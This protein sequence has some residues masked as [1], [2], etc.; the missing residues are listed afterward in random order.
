[1][2]WDRL[3]TCQFGRPL[4][5]GFLFS[6]YGIDELG[7]VPDANVGQV[8]LVRQIIEGFGLEIASPANAREILLPNGTI[9]VGLN[10]TLAR[11]GL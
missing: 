9:G 10:N 11:E 7:L 8:K 3:H 6:K 4:Q 5:A 1:L 2:R